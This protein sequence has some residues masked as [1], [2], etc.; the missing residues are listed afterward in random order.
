MLHMEVRVEWAEPLRYRSTTP[1]E[2]GS[3]LQG[4]VGAFIKPAKGALDSLRGVNSRGAHVRRTNL[5][6]WV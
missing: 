2:V 6:V 1:P 3:V 5:H 4:A